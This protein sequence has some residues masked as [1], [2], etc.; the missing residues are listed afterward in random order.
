MGDA[1]TK[2]RRLQQLIEETEELGIKESESNDSP[3]VQVLVHDISE[4]CRIVTSLWFVLMISYRSFY[5]LSHRANSTPLAFDD[6]D[7]SV[8]RQVFYLSPAGYRRTWSP[9]LREEASARRNGGLEIWKH[10]NFDE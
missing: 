4:V 2:E 6:Y 3:D 1:L 7:D 5:L 10:P 9:Y 8:V